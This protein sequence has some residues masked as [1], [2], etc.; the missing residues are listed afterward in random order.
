MLQFL[1]ENLATIIIAAVVFGLMAWV[2]IHKVRQRQKGESGC[3]CGCAGC[4]EASSCH[5]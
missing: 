4:S 5:K 1:K 2:V 3:G